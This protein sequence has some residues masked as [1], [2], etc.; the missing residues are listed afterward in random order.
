MRLITTLPVLQDLM[1]LDA[2]WEVDGEVQTRDSW[3]HSAA[4]ARGSLFTITLNFL[5]SI[6]SWTSDGKRGR[7]RDYLIALKIPNKPEQRLSAPNLSILV[8]LLQGE[9]VAGATC[10]AQVPRDPK[11]FGITFRPLPEGR[12]SKDLPWLA[13][14][15]KVQTPGAKAVPA[16]QGGFGTLRHLLGHPPLGSQRGHHAAVTSLSI[17]WWPWSS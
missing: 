14:G 17:S 8:F 11:Y 13:F 9:A 16:F 15:G 6:V 4:S 1:S 12:T 7:K 3:P 5:L 10:T 2:P